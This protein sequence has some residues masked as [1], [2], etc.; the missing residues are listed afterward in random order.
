M[1]T[2]SDAINHYAGRAKL[3]RDRLQLIEAGMLKISDVNPRQAGN[4]AAAIEAEREVANIYER[5][6]KRL[7][8]TLR[9]HIN[10]Q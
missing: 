10:C 3:S 1:T 9:T 7:G 4:T 5:I 6:V 2:R 8:D